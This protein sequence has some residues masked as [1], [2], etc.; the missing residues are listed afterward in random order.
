MGQALFRT[1][2]RILEATVAISTNRKAL[3]PL[4]PPPLEVKSLLTDFRDIVAIPHS[5]SADGRILVMENPRIKPQF[6]L[7]GTRAVFQ[8]PWRDLSARA[9]DLRFSLWG[10]QGFLYRFVLCLLE[11]KHQIYSLHACALYQE[12]RN[13]LFVVAGG[14]G[15]G[16]TVYLLSG[17]EH[18]LAL[19][20]TETVHFR[21]TKGGYHWFKGSL[22]DNVRLG[23]LRHHFPRFL[24]KSGGRTPA[25]EWQEKFALDLSSFQYPADSL[26]NPD[27]IVLFPRIEEGWVDFGLYPVKDHR[28]AAKAL[29]DNISEKISQS[30]V[31][32]DRLPLPG[33][34]RLDLTELRWRAAQRLSQDRRTVLCASVL[35]DPLHCWGNLLEQEFPQRSPK[36]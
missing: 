14:A 13:R 8:G 24:P 20:S 26:V 19:F 33:L 5:A 31:L 3:F 15:S 16:K 17:I 1:G 9:S 30:V 10:N 11:L 28:T 27:V 34:D 22:V 29:F 6:S 18:G 21:Q 12:K 4:L 23:T 25:A 35:S 7:L 2:V 32:Y 36:W